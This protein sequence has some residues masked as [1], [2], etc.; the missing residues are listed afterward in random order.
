MGLKYEDYAHLAKPQ[1]EKVDKEISEAQRQQEDRQESTPDTTDWEKRYKDLEVAYSRQGQQIGEYRKLV[2]DYLSSTPE[3]EETQEVRPITSDDIFDDPNSAVSKVV[4]N[5][6]A[7]KRVTE[8]EKELA[9]TRADAAREAFRAKHPTFDEAVASP[10]FAN[11]INS[12]TTRVE[13]AQRADKFDMIAADAL[14]SLWEAEH[15]RPQVP[16]QPDPSEVTLESGSGAEPPAPERYSRSEML[17]VMTRAKQGD[18]QAQDYYKANAA[19]YRQAL[20]TGNV[21]D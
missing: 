1:E 10:E 11:W 4:E 19:A 15:S 8:L 5:H 6:P 3:P 7:I 21:R 20:A 14:F 16:A 9:Q 18:Q 13:L 2:D 12:D 17:R